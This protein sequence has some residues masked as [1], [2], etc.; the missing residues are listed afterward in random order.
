[1]ESPPILESLRR[2]P[3][4]PL[5]S[6]IAFYTGYR[7]VGQPRARHRGLPSPFLTLIVTFDVP[8]VVSAHPRPEQAPGRYDVLLGGL[9]SS[10]ALIETDGRQSGIQ[11][12][13]SPLGARALFGLPAG[14]LAEIDVPAADVAGRGALEAWERLQSAAS[15]SERFA[16]VDDWLLTSAQLDRSPAVEVAN[17][18]R[19]L[20][21]PGPATSMERI[22]G[23]VGWSGRH[24]R[25]RLR[26]ETGLTPMVAARVARFDRARR[27]LQ[28]RETTGRPLSLAD[29]AAATGYF[30]QAHLAREFRELAGCPPSQWLAEEFRNVQA[31]DRRS[32]AG[33]SS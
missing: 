13:V 32:R 23:A 1:M 7:Q 18:W 17:A 21:R 4:P 19:L 14:E 33:S 2:L 15:W 28:H 9:H 10:H 6:L 27:L 31:S 5:R 11:I 25:S 12:H 20:A 24:L 16:V 3:A 22:A 26:E 29:L 8:L 30:D